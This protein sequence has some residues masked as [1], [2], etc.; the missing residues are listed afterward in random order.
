MFQLFTDLTKK[1]PAIDQKINEIQSQLKCLPEG[2]LTIAHNGKNTKWYQS[3]G[4]NRKYIPKSNRTL[5]EQLALRKY[6]SLVLEELLQEKTAISFYDRHRSIESKSALILQDSSLGYSELLSPYFQ[7]PPSH[8]AWLQENYDRS[9]RNLEN[10]IYKTV[11]G[12]LVR[13]KSEALIAMLL[14]TNKIPFR[15]ECALTLGDIKFYPD[16]TILHPKTDR[17]FYWEHFGFSRIPA[18]HFLQATS[19][20]NTRYPSHYSITHNLR[21]PDAS[22][23]YRISRKNDS[24]LFLAMIVGSFLF[25]LFFLFVT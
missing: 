22:I 11:N 20:C 23:K 7:V 8:T 3:D 12:I 9:S 24:I 14:Y 4:Q 16:F 1:S 15:Y 5:A 10:L 13:S 18:K 6:L 25:P 19:L 17:I 21:E 2:K